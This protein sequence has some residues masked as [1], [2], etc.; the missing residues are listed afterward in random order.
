MEWLFHSLSE[1]GC[2]VEIQEKN[3]YLLHVMLPLGDTLTIRVG[4]A[5]TK[6]YLYKCKV[7]GRFWF[8]HNN[9]VQ[10]TKY[11]KQQFTTWSYTYS[12]Y[13]GLP[14]IISRLNDE[15]VA[16]RNQA[17]QHSLVFM[18]VLRQLVCKDM[19]WLLGR[20]HYALELKRARD[21]L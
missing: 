13:R 3:P 19:A 11:R 14:E 20:T 9:D 12:D 16:L 2:W 21:S 15:E 7:A 5:A 6:F 1:V 10:H 17:Q 4:N 18:G 8:L